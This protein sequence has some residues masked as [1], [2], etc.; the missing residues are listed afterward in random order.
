MATMRTIP[1]AV[2]EIKA[3][4]PKTALTVLGLRRLVRTG[5]LRA[6]KIGK[7]AFISM[8]SL[9]AFLRGEGGTYENS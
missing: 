3:K 5:E 2:E 9:E 4:D 1:K 8:E 6:A 7:R